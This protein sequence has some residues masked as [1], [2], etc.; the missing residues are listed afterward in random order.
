MPGVLKSPCFFPALPTDGFTPEGPRDTPSPPASSEAKLGAN[1]KTPESRLL[2]FKV[3]QNPAGEKRGAN[4]GPG[5]ALCLRCSGFG[6]TLLRVSLAADFKERL[7]S[8]LLAAA[9][10]PP[11]FTPVLPCSA[12]FK[13]PG[14]KFSTSPRRCWV[15]IRTEIPRGFPTLQLATAPDPA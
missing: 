5:Q 11:T 14:R 6:R 1:A 9:L 4:L 3:C 13:C 8:G 10:A 15:E 7:K 2:T 12:L